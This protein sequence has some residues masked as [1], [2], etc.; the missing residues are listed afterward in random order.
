MKVPK[1]LVGEIVAIQL[2][3]PMYVF[4]Y[5][6]HVQ[7]DAGAPQ[8]KI[9][10]Q[11]YYTPREG[12][13]RQQLE[14][15]AADRYH[16]AFEPATRDAFPGVRVLAV[17]EDSVTFEVPLPSNLPGRVH[18][19]RKTVG[20]GDVVSLDVLP[21]GSFQAAGAKADQKDAPSRIVAP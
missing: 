19:V 10:L 16:E 1:E 7:W 17:E 13:D 14:V 18:L 12:L 5:A 21:A 4:T 6:A 15:M 20:F 2:A 3:R 11:H 9:A 8:Q